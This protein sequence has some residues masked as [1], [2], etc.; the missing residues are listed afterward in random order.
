MAAA[1]GAGLPIEEPT[2]NMIVD[3]GGGTAEVAVISLGGMV[4][5]NSVRVA[6]QKLDEAITQHVRRA[7]SVA[8]GER[9]SED[10]KIHIGSA[11]PLEAR[12]EDADQGPRPG[13]QAC[14]APWR[15]AARRSAAP[16]KSPCSASSTASS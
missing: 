15:S 16:W 8:I 6:G 4:E 1:V 10:I 9:T 14:P 5:F 3:M 11:F 2:G 13:H 12:A 7:Y